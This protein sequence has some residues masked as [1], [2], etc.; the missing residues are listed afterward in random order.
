[1]SP[2][3]IG[4]FRTQFVGNGKFVSGRYFYRTSRSLNVNWPQGYCLGELT[5]QG[6]ERRS[7]GMRSLCVHSHGNF[8][9]NAQHRPQSVERVPSESI[10]WIAA[11]HSH[12]SPPPAC[13]PLNIYVLIS[14]RASCDPSEFF[15]ALFYC[16]RRRVKHFSQKK[17]F[18]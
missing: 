5:G 6:W 14:R 15:F 13:H 1:M 7:L 9:D 10:S 4:N 16:I 2:L 18:I 11:G 12:F 8:N 3:S 17:L